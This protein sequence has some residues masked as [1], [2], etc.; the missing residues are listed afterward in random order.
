LDVS[1]PPGAVDHEIPGRTLTDDLFD[2]SEEI[3]DQVFGDRP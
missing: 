2:F 3:K 1:V